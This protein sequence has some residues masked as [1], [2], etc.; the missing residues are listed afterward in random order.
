MLKVFV[1]DPSLVREALLNGRTL[2]VEVSERHHKVVLG[3]MSQLG[4]HATPDGKYI[5]PRSLRA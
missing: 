1:V 3:P 4:P 2:I 5:L